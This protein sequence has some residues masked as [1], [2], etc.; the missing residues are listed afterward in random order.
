MRN[1]NP[2]AKQYTLAEIVDHDSVHRFCEAFARL[3]G[4][5]L[6]VVD[7]DCTEIVRAQ[8]PEVLCNL[9]EQQQVCD[10]KVTSRVVAAVDPDAGLALQR[11]E[12]KCGLSHEVQ[13]I[14]L[15]GVLLGWFVAGPYRPEDSSGLQA[16]LAAVLEGAGVEQGSR[17]F[18]ATLD[19]LENMEPLPP[20]EFGNLVTT[21]GEAMGVLLRDG[22]ERCITARS[23]MAAIQEAYNQLAE[24]NQRLAESVEE[25]KSLDRMKS[26]FLATV[27]HE[28]RTPLTSIVGYSEMLLEGM[29]GSLEQVQVEYLQV[30]MEKGEQLM[31]IIS[32]VLDISKI[33]T[34]KTEL[35]MEWVDLGEVVQDV[36]EAKFHEI[37]NRD[38]VIN[39]SLGEG[40]PRVWA[41]KAKIRQVLL[42]LLS[43]AVKFT[44]SSG[45][46]D[47]SVQ[48]RDEGD[49]APARGTPRG[50]L[51]RISDSGI[52]IPA[53][54]HEQ[55][56]EA[57]FQVDSSS[58]REYGGTGLGLAIVKNFVEAH[59]GQVWLDPAVEQGA[60]FLVLLPVS[61]SSGG[62]RTT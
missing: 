43:N 15:Q 38:M 36:L 32:E 37:E 12:C 9:M 1:T 17:L 6:A 10:G 45:S 39:S 13:E 34:G 11:R 46:V 23:H 41:D 31:Q 22:Y 27:S 26:S 20:A 55:V 58:T 50:V 5:S 60:S 51:I 25:L 35:R 49:D 19:R 57:F 52:G 59:G 33:E 54:Y 42:N 48:G 40:L 61:P 24:K 4:V 62:T 44:P 30:I 47:I 14:R 28:L 8:A 53:E 56:F 2:L 29:A 18:R 7:R 3:H 21:L 16:S